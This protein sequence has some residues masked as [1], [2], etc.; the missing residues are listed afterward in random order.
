MKLTFL[1]TRGEIEART[2]R[3][4]MHSSLLVSYR[5]TRVMIDC[6]LDWLGKFERL[7]PRAIVLTHAH[8]DHAWGLEKRRALPR[9]R[10]A[11]DM[12]NATNL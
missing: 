9:I 10:S 4:R 1:G 3:H 6:G 5:S 8:P 2:R 11:K 12:A 7:R